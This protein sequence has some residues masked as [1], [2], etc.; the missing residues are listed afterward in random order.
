MT[1]VNIPKSQ[2][3]HMYNSVIPFLIDGLKRIGMI[4]KITQSEKKYSEYI[5]K[6]SVEHKQ[7]KCKNS[8]SKEFRVRGIWREQ[9]VIC[10]YLEK[11]IINYFMNNNIIE[12]IIIN[13]DQKNLCFEG[14]Q[15]QNLCDIITRFINV[16][17]KKLLHTS[18]PSQPLDNIAFLH[19]NLPLHVTI[20]NLNDIIIYFP[21]KMIYDITALPDSDKHAK[22]H[23]Y[24]S[25]MFPKYIKG[26]FQ[27]QVLLVQEDPDNKNDSMILNLNNCDLYNT[28][29]NISVNDL[30]NTFEKIAFTYYN[31]KS[32]FFCKNYIIVMY[33]I[34][35]FNSCLM[36]N[37]YQIH[38]CET[39]LEPKFWDT[40]L[41]PTNLCTDF[42]KNC[43]PCLNSYIQNSIEAT[44]P[45]GSIKCATSGCPK[46]LMKIT[47]N[48]D[49]EMKPGL[50][51]L[52]STKTI[53]I[54]NTHMLKFESVLG[55]NKLR[56]FEAIA[57][58][59]LLAIAERD[60]IRIETDE[61]TLKKPIHERILAFPYYDRPV[62]SE[63]VLLESE[64]A[65]NFIN[66]CP[67]C[68]IMVIKDSG[69][70]AMI[71]Q[72]CMTPFCIRCGQYDKQLERC[73]CV[74]AITNTYFERDPSNEVYTDIMQEFQIRA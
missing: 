72:K 20:N 73:S 10:E 2:L 23:S 56:G 51:G 69:C 67:C 18:Y 21:G 74:L 53:K 47:D 58:S 39:C 45:G 14:D 71:C 52:L 9:K 5:I 44:G 11:R 46:I 50:I 48:G 34:G 55:I 40:H 62:L 29:K 26:Y 32:T 59:R 64:K 30:Y 22:L 57:Q 37:R 65:K 33:E 31:V 49:L 27:I 38:N 15:S 8:N 19:G 66:I 6:F 42:K 3:L 54:I 24:L 17:F 13:I 36:F 1:R 7:R 16:N 63:F 60:K 68:N 4:V 41:T 28:F 70:P 43:I 35:V 12:S 61:E 25:Y